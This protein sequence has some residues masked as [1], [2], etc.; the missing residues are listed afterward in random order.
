MKAR[1][2]IIVIAVL[3]IFTLSSYTMVNLTKQESDQRE[4]NGHD[5]PDTYFHVDSGENILAV[6]DYSTSSDS[7]WSVSSNVP[8]GLRFYENYWEIN[9]DRIDSYGHQSCVLTSGSDIFCWN[10]NESGLINGRIINISKSNSIVDDLA[11]GGY[12]SCAIRKSLT[13]KEVFCWENPKGGQNPED[14]SVSLQKKEVLEN[15]EKLSAGA[16]HFCGAT[17]DHRIFCWG[18]GI[19]GQL[20][21]G[22]N[23]E[24][25]VPSM[26][27][28][29][30]VETFQDLESGSFHSCVL[31]NQ[32]RVFCWGWN[33][34]G[35]LGDGSYNNSNIP[36]EVSFPEGM[37]ALKISAGGSHSCALL[38]NGDVYCWGKND[39]KQ[40]NDS[41]NYRFTYPVKLSLGTDESVKSIQ[42]GSEHTCVYFENNDYRCLGMV[43]SIILDVNEITSE[44]SAGNGYNCLIVESSVRCDGIMDFTNME[45][46]PIELTTLKVP[47]L[48]QPGTLAGHI[49]SLE[50]SVISITI[51]SENHVSEII[52]ISDYADSGDSDQDGWENNLEILCESDPMNVTSIPLDYDFDGICDVID[53]DDDNDE[54]ID[55]HDEFPFDRFEWRDS[56]KDGV[57]SNSDLIEIS[58]TALI[59]IITSFILILL[60][61][62]EAL[63][64]MRSR[65]QV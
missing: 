44:Q 3:M 50:G 23:H 26:I 37:S 33:A 47:D 21:N 13:D 7:K 25:S 31:V 62:L 34:H 53:N 10:L 43:N 65:S 52:L 55:S 57:G 36:V 59:A 30:P 19:M 61:T 64:R 5:Y 22:S 39:K 17:E 20:G 9:G 46:V 38:N 40:I 42:L 11:V 6:P 51:E 1:F 18:G 2:S 56:D 49:R 8:D 63:H 14:Y 35:Q 27:E 4:P 29:F 45:S 41:E 58:T 15:W 16:T 32:G 12:H 60:L 24:T 54:V 48:I 28:N